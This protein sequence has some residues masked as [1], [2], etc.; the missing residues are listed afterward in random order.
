MRV[1]TSTTEV[2]RGTGRRAIALILVGAGLVACTDNTRP[3]PE[4]VETTPTT[5][6][7]AT[8]VERPNPGALATVCPDPIVIQLDRPLD[9][10][11]LP[12]VGVSAVDGLTGASAYRGAMLDPLSVLPL[13]IEMRKSLKLAA[14]RWGIFSNNIAT[15]RKWTF[16]CGEY[17]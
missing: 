4:A 14:G 7:I 12:F 10:W 1:L 15:G 17:P 3:S 5:S 9:V 11:A 8:S 2:V 6:T 16:S 13:G